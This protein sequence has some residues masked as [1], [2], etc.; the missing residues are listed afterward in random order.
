MDGCIGPYMRQDM[1]S[2]SM[3]ALRFWPR[4]RDS[5]MPTCNKF[6]ENFFLINKKKFLLNE[7][8]QVQ[9][10]DQK[11]RST[12]FMPRSG[13]STFGMKLS[14][15]SSEAVRKAANS[16]ELLSTDV[17]EYFRFKFILFR[18]CLHPARE[19]K[20]MKTSNQPTTSRATF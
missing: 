12:F 3:N 9:L 1:D 18:T 14:L 6:Q 5:F 7:K 20:E 13:L 19:S 10:A 2:S 4:S 17:P 8:K 15:N 16:S 11:Q